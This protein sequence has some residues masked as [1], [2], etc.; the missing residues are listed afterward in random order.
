MD[1]PDRRRYCFAPRQSKGKLLVKYNPN[2]SPIWQ[3]AAMP[4]KFVESQFPVS[5]GYQQMAACTIFNAYHRTGLCISAGCST[6]GMRSSAV[7]GIEKYFSIFS[8]HIEV[9]GFAVDID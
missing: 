2:F 6:L 7:F 1:E 3:S 4:D 9:V 5:K 8:V